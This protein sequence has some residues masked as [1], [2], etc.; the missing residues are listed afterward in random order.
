MAIIS[1]PEKFNPANKTVF[2]I[3]FDRVNHI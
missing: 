2:P 3:Y 1:K